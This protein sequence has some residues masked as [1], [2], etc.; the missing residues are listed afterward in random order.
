MTE[1]NHIHRMEEGAWVCGRTLAFEDRELLRC[2]ARDEAEIDAC[3]RCAARI[4]GYF[5]PAMHIQ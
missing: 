2:E 5:G 1:F 4:L 3:E